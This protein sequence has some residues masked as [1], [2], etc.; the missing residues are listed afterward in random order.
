M[1]N[2]GWENSPQQIHEYFKA[3]AEEDS[4]YADHPA[5]RTIAK[6]MNLIRQ[7]SVALIRQRKDFEYPI[8]VLAD[9]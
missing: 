8:D 4:A 6:Y 5:L 1:I 3:K 2:K 7:S 9:F